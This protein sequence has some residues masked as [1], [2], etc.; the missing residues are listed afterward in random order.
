MAMTR[1]SILIEKAE[2]TPEKQQILKSSLFKKDFADLL[3]RSV[4]LT[5]SIKMYNEQLNQP[6]ASQGCCP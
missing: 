4:E 5:D 6:S 3:K 2:Q 1:L